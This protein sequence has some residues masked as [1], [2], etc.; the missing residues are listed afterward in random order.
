M[1]RDTC[2]RLNLDAL[3]VVGGDDSNTN[4]AFLAQEMMADGVQV[5]GVPKTIDGDIQ[6]RDVD[7]QVLCAMSFGF[8][9]AARAFAGL[10][11]ADFTRQMTVQEL[12]PDGIAGLGPVAQ[13]LAMLEGLDAHANA[14]TVRLARLPREDE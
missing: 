14:V 11:L 7:G 9:T 4:A 6:V 8:H 5:L 12:T 2:R 13:T 1:I 10:S 3:V